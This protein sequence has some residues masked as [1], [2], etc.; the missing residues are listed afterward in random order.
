[1]DLGT[2]YAGEQREDTYAALKE[3]LVELFKFKVI[4]LV[5]GGSQDLTYAMYRAYDLTDQTV[6]IA[7]VDSRFDLG[8]QTEMPLNEFN[9]LS[10]IILKKALPAFQFCEPGLS[11]LLYSSGRKSTDGKDA[12]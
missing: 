11:E 6:N 5:I 3:I 8:R 12:F 10:H 9:Y 2:L 4:P 7:A 1:M